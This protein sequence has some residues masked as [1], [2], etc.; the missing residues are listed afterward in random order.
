VWRHGAEFSFIFVFVGKKRA[1]FFLISSLNVKSLHKKI[2][3][4]NPGSSYSI[5]SL[6]NKLFFS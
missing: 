2:M 3:L 4:Q 1:F 5:F 6:K